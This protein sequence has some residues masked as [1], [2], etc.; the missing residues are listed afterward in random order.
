LFVLCKF[1]QFISDANVAKF[2]YATIILTCAARCGCF[3]AATGLYFEEYD[4]RVINATE[5]ANSTIIEPEVQMNEVEDDMDP[6]N[7]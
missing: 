4:A 2:F 6:Y 7:Q 3:G 5:S 1:H